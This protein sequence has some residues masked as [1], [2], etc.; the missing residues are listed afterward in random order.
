MLSPPESLTAQA[1]EV[2]D[3]RAGEDRVRAGRRHGDQQPGLSAFP[4][5]RAGDVLPRVHP[6]ERRQNDQRTPQGDQSQRRKVKVRLSHRGSYPRVCAQ[7]AGFGALWDTID[8]SAM[9]TLGAYIFV[10]CLHPDSFQ[11]LVCRLSQTA[12]LKEPCTGLRIIWHQHINMNDW[13]GGAR[14]TKNVRL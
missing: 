7:V 5:Q 10:I 12:K 1:R 11:S 8:R 3:A 6:P 4:N 14:R 2:V 9:Q 13:V